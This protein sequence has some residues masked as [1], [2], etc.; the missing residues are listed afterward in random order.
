MS[1]LDPIRQY[2]PWSPRRITYGFERIR[3][4]ADEAD[5]AKRAD[6]IAAVIKAED[7]GVV[8]GFIRHVMAVAGLTE[9]D[10]KNAKMR[11]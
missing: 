9:E 5:S 2:D 11:F 3:P 7:A 6:R 4:A 10:I 8:R 1:R